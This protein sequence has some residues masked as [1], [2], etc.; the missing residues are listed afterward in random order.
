MTL[1][2]I[3]R[4]LLIIAL[5]LLTISCQPKSEIPS[6][7]NPTVPV[8]GIEEGNLASDFTL[9][10]IEGQVVTLGSLRGN[11]VMLNFWA[12]WC[13][14][15][16]NEMP[17]IQ[18]IYDKWQGEGLVILAINIK[19]TSSKVQLFMHSN[20]LSFP[21]LFDTDG[22]VSAMYQIHG[23]PTTLFIDKDGIIKGKNIGSF[24][25][26]AE[27]EDYLNIIMP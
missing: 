15:C 9:Q 13:G 10:D 1:K 6:T 23:I 8:D 22:N 20:N 5:L 2:L 21:V 4:L 14:P 19:E 26:A 27:I 3:I 16:R 18:E 12:T 25:N 11:P 24:N 7:T 17:F